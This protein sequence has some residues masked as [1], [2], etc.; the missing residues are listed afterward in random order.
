[1]TKAR[2]CGVP[3]CGRTHHA[4]GLCTKHYQNMTKHGVAIAPGNQGKK[5]DAGKVRE[6]RALA[7][8]FTGQSIA[9]WFGVDKSTIYQ[10]LRGE[11]W[12]NVA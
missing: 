4:K 1:M 3:K 11:T 2:L 5:L 12:R 6:I 8:S 10:I 7:D 9:K